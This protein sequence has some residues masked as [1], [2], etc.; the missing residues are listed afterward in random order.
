MPTPTPISSNTRRIGEQ[1]NLS[2]NLGSN[3]NGMSGYTVDSNGTI[4]FPIIGEVVVS[5]LTREQAA[6]LIKER[7]VDSK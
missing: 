1:S 2:A 3:S 7:L 6:N 4:D 5:G